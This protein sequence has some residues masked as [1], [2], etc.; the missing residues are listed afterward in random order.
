MAENPSSRT[1]AKFIVSESATLSKSHSDSK[2]KIPYGVAIFTQKLLIGS[3]YISF[4]LVNILHIENSNFY[5]ENVPTRTTV[6]A[7]NLRTLM[8]L[9]GFTK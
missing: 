3:I 9:S 6:L 5:F 8:T 1:I 2:N 7:G 4:N